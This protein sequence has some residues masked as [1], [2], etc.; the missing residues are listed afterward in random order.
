MFYFVV[1]KVQ[2]LQLGQR[3][4]YFVVE[5]SYRILSEAQPCKV[6]CKPL[7]PQRGQRRDS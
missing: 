5:L 2:F 3:G 1:V 4:K 6:L 7:Q